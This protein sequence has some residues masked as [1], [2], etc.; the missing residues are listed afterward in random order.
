MRA[1]L[2]LG[3][4]GMLL[5]SVFG[6]RPRVVALDAATGVERWSFA[7]GAAGSEEAGS[8]SGP[9]SD[10]TGVV[11]VGGHDDFVYALGPDGTLRF[12]FATLADVDAPPV[13]G[14]GG[15]LYVGG[16]DQRLY[17]IE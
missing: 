7:I 9:T 14:P 2:G 13:I 5:A 1:P 8:R 4:E 12:A 16:R 15:V 6:P 3:A 10:R 17:A 11:Y